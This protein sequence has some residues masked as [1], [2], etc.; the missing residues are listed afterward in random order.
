VL[1]EPIRF[2]KLLVASWIFISDLSSS[3]VLQKDHP[4][5]WLM[6]K[7]LVKVARSYPILPVS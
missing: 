3:Q 7:P 1:E 6:A 5:C 2:I 4:L